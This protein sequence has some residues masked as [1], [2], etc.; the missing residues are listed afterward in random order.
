MCR[1]TLDLQNV[2]LA[3]TIQTFMAKAMHAAGSLGIT[4]LVKGLG[5][6]TTKI[7]QKGLWIFFFLRVGHCLFN[8]SL[9]RKLKKENKQYF[10]YGKATS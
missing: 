7:L 5:K 3:L 10:Q 9:Y 1:V 8:S 4:M 6:H 2:L